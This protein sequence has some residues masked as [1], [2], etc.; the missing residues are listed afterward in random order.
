MRKA[1]RK[2]VKL[3]I[4]LTWPSGTGKTYSALLL[5]HGM[6]QNWAKICV[7]DTENNSA[8]LYS[9]LG[10][11]FVINLTAPFTPESYIKAIDECEKAWIE[12]II[13]D[14]ISHEWDW[15]GGV[16]DIHSSMSGN[17]FVNWSKVTPRHNNFIQKI[18][19]SPCHIIATMRTKSDYLIV[20]KN[21][22]ATPEKVGTKTITREGVEYEFTI[23]LDIDQKHQATASKDR[24][25]ML[26]DQPPFIITEETGKDIISWNNS[27]YDD[28]K[29]IWIERLTELKN[30][31]ELAREKK[32]EKYTLEYI[33]KYVQ[34]QYEVDW[35][36][37]MTEKQAKNMV[38]RVKK[39]LSDNK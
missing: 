14:S 37:Q 21:W 38:E 12:V 39:I 18:M 24:T 17:S 19:Q 5:A 1:E 16:L 20:D 31:I 7:I 32:P 3:K 25:S 15:Q 10:D 9:H 35:L 23:V 11:Y 8:E 6:C 2:V 22:K 33:A 13:I 34:A 28:N 36:E 4:G 26:I 30:L 29:P 27:W